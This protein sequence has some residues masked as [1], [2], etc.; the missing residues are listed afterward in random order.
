MD[1]HKD[2]YSAKQTE[3]EV[4]HL[5]MKLQQMTAVLGQ[6]EAELE[7]LDELIEK[8]NNATI[9]IF[10]AIKGNWSQPLR[11]EQLAEQAGF[12]PDDLDIDLEELED[13]ASVQGDFS[14]Y[15]IC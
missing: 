2:Y 8:W 6:K 9:K 7:Q 14:E 11:L 13:M 3:N 1:G 5:Q 12:N 4:L 15:D 10:E